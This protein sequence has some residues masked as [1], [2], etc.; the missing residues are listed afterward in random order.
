MSAILQ[1]GLLLK[2]HSPA[3]QATRTLSTASPNSRSRD[4]T[5]VRQRESEL[6]REHAHLP[7]MMGFVRN[8]VAQHLQANRP[9]P[10]PAVSAKLL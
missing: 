5:F 6:M 8:H 7:A 3:R 4:I 9:R 1:R 2:S 10:S